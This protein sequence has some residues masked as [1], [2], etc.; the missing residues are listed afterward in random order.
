VGQLDQRPTP[1]KPRPELSE[2]FPD[3]DD[4]NF[5]R[6]TTAQPHDRSSLN[7]MDDPGDFKTRSRT[8]S[9]YQKPTS[10][11][12]FGQPKGPHLA[13]TAGVVTSTAPG[14][15]YGRPRLYAPSVT[16]STRAQW[17][18]NRFRRGRFR[19]H[20]T[21]SARTRFT[22]SRLDGGGGINVGR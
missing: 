10:H 9:P 12:T 17:C 16:E 6:P 15:I 2:S 20:P 3:V 14:S 13:P 19:I 5:R 22:D 7:F 11:R 18:R 1:A 4:E 8:V 21:H